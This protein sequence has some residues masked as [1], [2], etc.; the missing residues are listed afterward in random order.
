MKAQSKPCT[1]VRVELVLRRVE[2]ARLLDRLAANLLNERT[3]GRRAL[4]SAS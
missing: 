3:R 1:K 4:Q 2:D